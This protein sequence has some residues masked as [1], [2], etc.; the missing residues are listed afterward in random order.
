L[1]FLRPFPRSLVRRDCWLIGAGAS[2][3][4]RSSCL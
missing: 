4:F 1:L 2:I 3:L